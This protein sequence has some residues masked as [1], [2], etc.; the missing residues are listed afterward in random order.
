MFKRLRE[1]IAMKSNPE[2]ARYRRFMAERV[3]GHRIKYVTERENDIDKVIGRSGGINIR[4]DELIVHA[5]SE[6]VFR[7]RIPELQTS[8]LMSRDGVVFTGLDLT[9]GRERSIIVHFVDYFK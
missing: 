9:T 3:C 6:I 2:S 8:E 5:S 1:K 4:D 7:A